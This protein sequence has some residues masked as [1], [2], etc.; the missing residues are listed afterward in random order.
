MREF[1]KTSA[2]HPISVLSWSV[3]TLRA[4]SSQSEL[5]ASAR[6][7]ELSNDL[8]SRDAELVRSQLELDFLSTSS[9]HLARHFFV[10]D[11]LNL[12]LN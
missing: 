1:G 7:L 12:R 5:D 3:E 11:S 9:F 6:Q 10:L 2:I 8:K 4:K